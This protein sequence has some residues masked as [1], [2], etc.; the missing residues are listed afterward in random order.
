MA[1]PAG[2]GPVSHTAT[3]EVIPLV[4]DLFHEPL[5][6]S[7]ESGPTDPARQ[8][9]H[10]NVN[11]Y[12]R[13]RN[14]SRGR[15]L[16]LC[17]SPGYGAFITDEIFHHCHEIAN[18]ELNPIYQTFNQVKS[19]SCRKPVQRRPAKPI[20]G[21]R[22]TGKTRCS[23]DIAMPTSTPTAFIG[24]RIHATMATSLEVNHGNVDMWIGTTAWDG[25]AHTWVEAINAGGDSD[26]QAITLL[27]NRNQRWP[28]TIDLNE[29]P[30]FARERGATHPKTLQETLDEET[31]EFKAKRA[32]NGLKGLQAQREDRILREE[33]E[34]N[35]AP[36]VDGRLGVLSGRFGES[37][38]TV[39]FDKNSIFSSG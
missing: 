34:Q 23:I 30:V 17:I 6:S 14:G 10:K 7:I 24:M 36:A 22:S 20:R 8:F 9:C 29:H 5:I 2:L 4:F 35:A 13:L 15:A 31:R 26:Q 21:S 1:E 19:E 25:T 28:I 32:E 33:L 18:K 3:S 11:G 38:P 27:D 39:P 16:R 37:D 12:L